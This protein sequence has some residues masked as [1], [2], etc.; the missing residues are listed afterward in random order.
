MKSLKL[1]LLLSLMLGV[2]YPL[3]ITIIGNIIFPNQAR[4][5]LVK[6]NGK[7]VGSRLIGQNFTT[8]RYFHTRPSVTDNNAEE[9]WSAGVSI[10]SKD[11]LSRVKKNVRERR[12]NNNEQQ[13]PVEMV[14]ASASGIDPHIT[15][16]VAIF[17]AK[18][19]A[20]TRNMSVEKVRKLIKKNT[21]KRLFGPDLVN[22]LLLNI[23]LDK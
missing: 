16:K 5:S 9:A 11:F 2:A 19:V 12:L 7:T 6:V 21:E 18:R 4:G 14:T 15:K 23:E 10:T 8:D 3:S 20:R 22:V 1:F 13:I 17:Q